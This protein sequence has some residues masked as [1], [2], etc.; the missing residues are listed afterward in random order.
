MRKGAPRLPTFFSAA[1]RAPRKFQRNPESAPTPAPC[2]IFRKHPRFLRWRR[3]Y[4]PNKPFVFAPVEQLLCGFAV[5]PACF[6]NEK[7]FTE[8][9][10]RMLG[11]VNAASDWEGRN[12]YVLLFCEMH[13]DFSRREILNQ[14][15]RATTLFCGAGANKGF[16]ISLLRKIQCNEVENKTYLFLP[17]QLDAVSLPKNFR[18]HSL[19]PDQQTEILYLKMYCTFTPDM[20]YH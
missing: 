3:K 20:G 19:P 8:A 16:K 17:S 15:R 13:A 11:N 9:F 6:E 18:S 1:L 12:R 7:T 4:F 14:M 10:G 5:D 2:V